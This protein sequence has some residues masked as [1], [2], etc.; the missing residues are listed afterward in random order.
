MFCV[1]GVVVACVLCVLMWCCLQ[2][3]CLL[4]KLFCVILLCY[5]VIVAMLRWVV[6]SVGFVCALYVVL[7]V[8]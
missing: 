5:C 2:F 8:F 7:R 3:G 1:L 6:N 4:G